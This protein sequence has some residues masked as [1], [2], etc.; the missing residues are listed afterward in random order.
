MQPLGIV[1]KLFVGILLTTL[2]I[3]IGRSSITSSTITSDILDEDS[4]S[5]T[6]SY[7]DER[8]DTNHSDYH[9]CIFELDSQCW[10]ESD[11]LDCEDNCSFSYR[12]CI[13]GN[14]EPLPVN[15]PCETNLSECLENCD[16]SSGECDDIG[17][18]GT[19]ED[20]IYG[21]CT[22][23]PSCNSSSWFC[24]LTEADCDDG[25]N[26]TVDIFS[27]GSCACLHDNSE[28]CESALDC[29]D[30]DRCTKDACIDEECTYTQKDE[31]D[32]PGFTTCN[33]GRLSMMIA[34][35]VTCS[36][37]CNAGFCVPD[38]STCMGGGD[39]GGGGGGG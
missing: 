21:I 5:S 27:P 25:K 23:N 18:C 19:C 12:A 30:D 38:Y 10:S 17:D 6:L 8:Y 1:G 34:C 28:C 14:Y 9:D 22:P 29:D 16:S 26:C 7:C 15:D 3:I 13:G 31:C 33:D 2:V 35:G 11:S 39:D 4:C 24:E 37:Y 20:C 36:C 32:C